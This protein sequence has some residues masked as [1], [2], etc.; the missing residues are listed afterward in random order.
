MQLIPSPERGPPR[1]S[2]RAK[3]DI[4]NPMMRKFLFTL[5]ALALLLAACTP[6]TPAPTPT[7]AFTPTPSPLP[8]T[9]TPTPMPLAARVDGAPILLEDYTAE[10]TRLQAAEAE[11]GLSSSPEAQRQQVLDALINETLLAQS[12]AQAG[13]ALSDE[14]LQQ[15][16]DGLI[17][18]LG[19]PAALTDWQARNGYTDE[20]FR[21]ALRRSLDAAAQREAIIATVPEQTEQ[22]LARQ[23]LARTPEGA[24]QALSQLNGGADFEALALTFDPTTGGMLGWFPQGYLLQPTVEDAV[25]MLQPGQ[26]TDVIQT[27]IGYHIVLV[28]QR[29]LHPLA[30]EA[31]LVLQQNQLDRWMTARRSTAAVEILVP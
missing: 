15:A 27:E 7:T 19:S 11:Q 16:Y 2:A 26:Y 25:F 1:K 21:R 5:T 30:P 23:I 6:A 31:R 17:A 3:Y 14:A 28:I 8:P 22:I 10:L 20:S 12:A 9:P 4:I 13:L 24:A 18:D 29:E